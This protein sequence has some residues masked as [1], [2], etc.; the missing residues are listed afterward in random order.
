MNASTTNKL[1]FDKEAL[2]QKIRNIRMQKNLLVHELAEKL[3]ISPTHMSNIEHGRANTSIELILSIANF[4]AV[5]LDELFQDSLLYKIYQAKEKEKREEEELANMM[6]NIDEQFQIVLSNCSTKE[7]VAY[8]K[9]ILYMK[10][11]K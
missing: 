4:F 7:K 11:L 3:N 1:T 8:L 6:A 9:L 5:S 2:G 10:K